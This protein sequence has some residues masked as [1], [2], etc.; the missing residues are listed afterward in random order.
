M[1]DHY[2]S[3]NTF[4]GHVLRSFWFL[5]V[6]GTLGLQLSTTIS[7]RSAAILYIFLVLSRVRRRRVV[8]LLAARLVWVS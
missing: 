7:W 3:E 8:L 4:L 2:L 5:A 1:F 6:F